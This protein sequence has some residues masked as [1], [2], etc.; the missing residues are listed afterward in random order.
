MHLSADTAVQDS[1][2]PGEPLPDA[3]ARC[4][5]TLR[6]DP[7]ALENAAKARREKSKGC[8][9]SCQSSQVSPRPANPEVHC[10]QAS[11]YRSY[12]V[13]LGSKPLS[14]HCNFQSGLVH[15]CSQFYTVCIP[16]IWTLESGRGSR[17]PNCLPR[18]RAYC[19]VAAY[20]LV[21]PP[22]PPAPP[23]CPA[24]II[25]CCLGGKSTNLGSGELGWMLA[26]RNGHRG[27]DPP[28]DAAEQNLRGPASSRAV[29]HIR[30]QLEGTMHPLLHRHGEPVGWQSCQR[31]LRG[32]GIL[33][34]PA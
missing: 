15:R 2:M 31:R 22:A 19:I 13:R 29:P 30:R 32:A 7:F 17:R 14:V 11:L 4:P 23:A 24:L 27:M 25:R 10:S 3:N 34:R 21:L 12:L 18:R 28:R 8:R 6:Y 20:I 26:I 33:R 9:R 16:S 1:C 5:G